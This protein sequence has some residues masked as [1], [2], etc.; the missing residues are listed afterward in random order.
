MS[1][2]LPRREKK[3]ELTQVDRLRTL[4]EVSRSLTAELDLN[5]IM[6][7]ILGAAIRVIPGADAGILFLYRDDVRKLVASHAVGMA[8]PAYEIAIEPGEGLAGKAFLSGKATLY[9]D[10]DATELGMSGA[11]RHNLDRFQE[12]TGGVRFPESAL[13]AGLV[14]KGE[15]I[16][17]FVVENLYVPHSFSP[18]DLDIVDGLAQAAAIA[19]VNARLFE[20]ERDTRIKLEALNEEIRVQRDQLQRRINVQESL[21][22]VVQ[23]R[24]PLTV[25]ATRLAALTDGAVVIL[26]AL[27]RIRAAEPAPE[28]E[29]ARELDW[30][31]SD[32][33]LAALDRAG[34]TRAR[35]RMARGDGEGE[36]VVWPVLGGGEV[37]GFVGVNSTRR[38]LDAVDEAAA[39]S[40]A[41][42][43]AAEFLKERAIE[44]SEIRSRE[45][46]LDE[47]LDGKTPVRASSF[48]ELRPPLG[49]AAGVLRRE[50][51]TAKPEL[52]LFRTFVAVTQEVVERSSA[53]AVV[54][55]R[56]HHVVI[57]WSLSGRR[58]AEVEN[59]LKT[60]A[61][62][63][64]RIDADLRPSFGIGV[65]TDRL[66]D[67]ADTYNEVRL[68]LEVREHLGRD[69]LVFQVDALGA[70]RFILRAAA[71][72]HVADFCQAALGPALEHDA[73]RNG[74]L[75]DTFRRYLQAGSS[76][77]GAAQ[78]LKVHPHTVQYRLDRLQ[79][80][81]GL[82][83][84]QPD[85]RLTLEMAL[86]VTDALGLVN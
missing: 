5:D 82:R 78:A 62:K 46:Q 80:M 63:L 14:Y 86:R 83:L 71:G 42:V 22:D 21:A 75:V 49:L 29:T 72:G 70:Y 24:L 34:T 33:L 31:P 74:A 54:T 66:E 59:D 27:N 56:G 35:Q 60:V 19:I 11:Q 7:G 79:R 15:P 41:L 43:A 8:R 38:E 68:G 39:D 51:G 53:P 64:Q 69:G 16:G 81:T 58:V 36:I 52:R 12:A 40:A 55:V 48:S 28:A 26:D 65:R 2:R 47:L 73:Q 32:L 67:L 9:A 44:E 57:I 3:A 10:R 45:D 13:S 4:I 37:L 6:R 61:A 1:K 77:K 50:K 25:L 84:N 30:L 23:E 85:E 76:V 18:F 17:A 20:S